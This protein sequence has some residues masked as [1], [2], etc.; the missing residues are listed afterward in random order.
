MRI[1][2]NKPIGLW[3]IG[4]P[5]RRWSDDININ[6]NRWRLN[7]RFT[8]KIRK[9]KTQYCLIFKYM[10]EFERVTHETHYRILRYGSWK[11]KWMWSLTIFGR[12]FQFIC[13]WRYLSTL[14]CSKN[15]SRS[16]W[17]FPILTLFAFRF[18]NVRTGFVTSAGILI[19][20]KSSFIYLVRSLFL[21]YV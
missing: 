8:P 11:A 3:S 16:A 15:L 10:K 20:Y 5:R 6:A 19:C 13:Y 4:R 1:D 9:K 2:R 7:R 12:L 18:Y 17:T 14:D 21:I